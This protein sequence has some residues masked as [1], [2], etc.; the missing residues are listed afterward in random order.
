MGECM[1]QSR[2][3][4]LLWDMN[5]TA[6]IKNNIQLWWPSRDLK[7]SSSSSCVFR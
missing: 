1:S 5:V 2:N 6:V 3:H 4:Q 7:Y